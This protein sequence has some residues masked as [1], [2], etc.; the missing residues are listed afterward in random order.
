MSDKRPLSSFPEGGSHTS[1]GDKYFTLARASCRMRLRSSLLDLRCLSPRTGLA[2]ASR[3]QET[4][5]P[6]P[7]RSARGPPPPGP[8]GLVVTANKRVP[9]APSAGH[10]CHTSRLERATGRLVHRRERGQPV[11]RRFPNSNLHAVA[12]FRQCAVMVCQA[13]RDV[14][15]RR[16][17]EDARV[18]RRGAQLYLRCIIV[19]SKSIS[20]T[21]AH[22]SAAASLKCAKH[23]WK[24]SKVFATSKA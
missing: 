6:R 9:L 19:D 4:W 13:P 15:V 3:N 1:R 18:R 16:V 2:S 23:C 12:P 5:R 24:R 10:L 14:R 20:L 7:G 11:R 17:R 22:S 21:Q 8:A